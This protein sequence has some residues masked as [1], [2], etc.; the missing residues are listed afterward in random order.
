MCRLSHVG[1]LNLQLSFNWLVLGKNKNMTSDLIFD[2]ELRV[3]NGPSEQFNFFTSPTTVRKASE[4]Q[5]QRFI[6][7]STSWNCKKRVD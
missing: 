3:L 2:V 6:E 7:M 1:I 4:K 5:G